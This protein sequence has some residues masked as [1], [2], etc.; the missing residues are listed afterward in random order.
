MDIIIKTRRGLRF[1]L[2]VDKHPTRPPLP[3]GQALSSPDAE[4]LDAILS[5]AQ[6]D[7]PK[8]WAGVWN[9]LRP[10]GA[11][12]LSGRN[13][14]LPEIKALAQQRRLRARACDSQHSD[15]CGHGQSDSERADLGPARGDKHAHTQG[16]EATDTPYAEKDATHSAAP[17]ADGDQKMADTPL[18]GDPV[19]MVS[20]EEML[21]HIDA[22]LPGPMTFAWQRTYRSAHTRDI[23]LGV[24]W[25]HSGSEYLDLTATSLTYVDAEG[26]RL[27]MSPPQIGQRS[28]YL[29]EGLDFDRQSDNTFVLKQA[30]QW[31]KVFTR[32]APSV[33][34]LR[35]TQ[36]RHP[37]YVPANTASSGHTPA[38]G[39]CID[40]HYNAQQRLSRIAGNW[41][42]SLRIARD[43]QGRIQSVSLRNEVR[44]QEKVVAEYDYNEEGD[45]VAQRNAKG[46]GET[47]RYHRHLLVQ[48]TLATGF[49]FYFEWDG[50]DHR[51]RCV[52]SWGERGIYDYHF[53]WHPDEQRSTTTDS[54]GFQRQYRYNAYGQVVEE[55]DNEGGVHRT[56]YIDGRKDAYTD[57]Q[58]HSTEYFYDSENHAVGLRDALGQRITLDYFRGRPTTFIDKDKSCWR[59]EYNRRG[60]L[61]ALIDPYQ[62]HTRY[63]YDAQGLVTS[64]TDPM[65]RRTRYRWSDQGELTELTDSRGQVQRF[66]YDPWGQVIAVAAL[67]DGKTASGTTKYR[68]NATG[69]VECIIAPNGDTTTYTYNASDQLIRHSDPCGRTTEFVYDGLSQVIERID[70]E[71]RRLQYEYDT[72]RNLTALTNEKGERH[73]FFYDGNERLIKEIGFDG[74]VQQYQ[75]NKA[76]HL[77]KHLDAGEV[78]TEFERDA[79][80]RMLTK[81]C[82]SLTDPSQAEEKIRYRYDAKG[83]L[84]ETYNAHH[85]L[86]FDYNRFGNLQHEHRSDISPRRKRMKSSMVDIGYSYIWPGLRSGIRLPD[87]Q[88]IRYGY[89]AHNQLNEIQ[90]DKAGITHI[91]RDALGRET[92]R[93]Q[94]ALVTASHYDPLGRLQRQASYHKQRKAPGPAQREY[95][96]NPFGNLGE[97][98]D[99][100]ATTRFIY[101]LVNRLQKVEGEHDERFSFDP[102]GN[103]MGQNGEI[104]GQ[105]EGNRLSMQGDRK[106]TYDARGNLVKECRGKGGKRETRFDYNLQ[107]QLVR[108]AREGQVTEYQYDPLG[109]RTRK[110]D[111]FGTTDYLWAGDQLVQE[112][113]GQ[114]TKTYIHEP[115]SFRPVAMVQDGQVYHYHLDH[116]GTPRELSDQGGKV[117]WKARYKTYGNV[118]VKDVEEVENNLRFQGQYYD[119]E[120]GLHY[121]RHRYYDP[122]AG[123]FISQDPIGLLGGVNNYQ[124][125][126]NPIS[127]V[128]PLGLSCKEQKYKTT[129]L[130]NEYVGENDPN[131]ASR[132]NSP[133][134]C[135]YFDDEKLAL[136][137]LNVKSGLIVEKATG[138]PFD[139]AGADTHWGDAIFVM[140][141]QGRIFASR[142]QLPFE[143]HHSSLGQGKPVASAGEI[144]VA[145]GKLLTSSNK[146]GHYAPSNDLNNQF[147]GELESRGMDSA[148]LDK[149]ER[150]GWKDD[151]TPMDPTPHKQLKS[152][153]NWK[154]GDKIPY[155]GDDFDEP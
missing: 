1:Q 140:D 22:T 77:I 60:Q 141:P 4:Q 51:A 32:P 121:N 131:N 114:S 73:Q 109:R 63:T 39:F 52:R 24:A 84:C 152:A 58:G 6:P 94:G 64:V 153:D 53:A 43:A 3:L 120:T 135:E 14:I 145:Q 21:Q 79:L 9:A 119:E 56:R 130:L 99:S 7:S 18:E 146:S 74:R 91:E 69:Q 95:G 67:P 80:G 151:G 144:N 16:P 127:W 87:G 128:D 110:K 96:Y 93:H 136:H 23:G 31:D 62:Q 48:R 19:S 149:V 33:S 81:T 5:E 106:F 105:A 70:A 83:R 123:Q 125:V 150:S 66:H 129:P 147:F 78:I 98:T 61:A 82:R 54:R 59:R 112:R 133:M 116:L 47:Y 155:D 30:G 88:E 37:A 13:E 27:P 103:L 26:R 55:I 25:S 154:P 17:A 139:T 20:G 65:R 72:E 34:R 85:Y 124:Y 42:K 104:D 115:E 108:V 134:V 86:A 118:A 50:E 2:V 10:F 28:K 143:L 49:N 97:L 36:L 46:V 15:R 111:A 11:K 40:L 90:L 75:Y 117:V 71:G 138:L 8:D 92:A 101:D 38:S 132:W 122:G 45:L 126:P 35:L 100:G 142:T 113:R 107:N 41:G 68:Y 12:A 29:P 137:E 102:A 44:R 76:G 57:P 148:E 89:D